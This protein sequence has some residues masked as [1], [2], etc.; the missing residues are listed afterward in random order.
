ML[1]KEEANVAEAVETFDA[2]NLYQITCEEG[3]L[4]MT[5]MPGQISVEDKAYLIVTND[6]NEKLTITYKTNPVVP[7]PI[8][9]LLD[10][11]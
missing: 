2:G 9:G 3:N 1:A 4:N 7:W 8:F 5:R 6:C 10:S 11:K